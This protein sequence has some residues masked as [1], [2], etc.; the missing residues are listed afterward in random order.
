[1]KVATFSLLYD[2]TFGIAAEQEAL[3]AFDEEGGAD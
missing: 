3:W 1:M 2:M